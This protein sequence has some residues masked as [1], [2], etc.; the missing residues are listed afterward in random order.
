MLEEVFGSLANGANELVY[1][2][3]P[4]PPFNPSLAEFLATLRIT[5]ENK[6]AIQ[7]DDFFDFYVDVSAEML[8][9][10]DVKFEQLLKETWSN[11]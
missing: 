10:D 7:L 5:E 2:A 11:Q 8:A 6:A 1:A 4:G 9:G 3:L